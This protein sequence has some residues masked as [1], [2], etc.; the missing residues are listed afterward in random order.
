MRCSL[1]GAENPDAANRCQLC[2]TALVRDEVE[3]PSSE[4]PSHIALGTADISHVSIR[5]SRLTQALALLAFLALPWL[6]MSDL[7]QTPPDVQQGIEQFQV[8]KARYFAEQERWDAQK[9]QVLKVMARHYQDHDLAKDAIP[10]EDIPF[11]VLLSYLVDEVN[12]LS[13]NNDDLVIYPVIDGHDPRLLISKEDRS[14]WPFRIALSLELMLDQDANGI[15]VKFLRLRR[16]SRSEN[17]ELAWNY[18]GP[19]LQQLRKLESYAGGV[20][21]LLLYRKDAEIAA[22][23]SSTYVSWQYQ[24]QAFRG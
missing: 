1:C 3:T 18:F 17:S 19:E 23:T 11:E 22:D 20:R 5:W 2:D 24:H 4:A 8:V 9:D 12:L 10:I 16:G 21:Q 13:A 6:M 15:H 14:L 7:F